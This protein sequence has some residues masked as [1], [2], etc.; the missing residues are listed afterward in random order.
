MA[1]FNPALH[2]ASSDERNWVRWAAAHCLGRVY[3][4]QGQRQTALP[5]FQTALNWY[6]REV[7][8]Q[9]AYRWWPLLAGMLSGLEAT[10]DPPTML[11]PAE[12]LGKFRRRCVGGRP[13]LPI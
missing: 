13:F 8:Q 6:E 4:A 7:W 2:F 9:W 11:H 5:H 10:Y 1:A 3:L 12:K